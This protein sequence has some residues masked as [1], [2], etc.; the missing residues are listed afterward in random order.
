MSAC[1]YV[2]AD[3]CPTSQIYRRRIRVLTW[4]TCSACCVATSSTFPC[5]L[6][7]PTQWCVPPHPAWLS[8]HVHCLPRP[9]W[10]SGR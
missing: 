3:N 10:N 4:R 5:G 2:V 7:W 1:M 8:Y 9:R 6:W